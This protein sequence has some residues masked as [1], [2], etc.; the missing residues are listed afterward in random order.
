[1]KDSTKK[2]LTITGGLVICAILVFVISQQFTK[3]KPTDDLPPVNSSQQGEVVVDPDSSIPTTDPDAS[4]DINENDLTVN[5]QTPPNDTSSNAGNGAVSSGTEQTIQA[6]PEVP[7]EPDE[8]TLT[9]P[10]QKPDGTPVEGTPTPEDH[11]T[12]QPPEP[13]STNTGGGL[14]GFDNV[15]NAGENQVTEAD[16]MYENGNKIGIM[17]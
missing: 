7:E 15:P 16:D 17:G 9:D 5:P 1:M 11:D 14:P 10:S 2:W 3:D 13:P 8:E 12:Y 4:S 6:D